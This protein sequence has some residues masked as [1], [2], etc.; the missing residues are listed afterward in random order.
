VTLILYGHLPELMFAL[1]D[2]RLTNPNTGAPVSSAATK[3]TL[4][5]GMWLHYTGL[6]EIDG[7]PTDL[8]LANTLY[9]QHHLPTAFFHLRDKLTETFRRMPWSARIKRHA[10]IGVGWV[11]FDQ[12]HTH[13]DPVVITVSNFLSPSGTWLAEAANEFTL[14]ATNL[15]EQLLPDTNPRFVYLQ[16]AGQGMPEA[17]RRQLYAQ[18][19]RI[20]DRGVISPHG[21]RL[22][23]EEMR[24]RSSSTGPVGGGQLVTVAPHPDL[25]EQDWLVLTPG[26]AMITCPRTTREYFDTAFSAVS[27]CLSYILIPE[28]LTAPEWPPAVNMVGM[29]PYV[30][31][32]T[33]SDFVF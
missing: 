28:D 29:D 5:P 26:P 31:S 14:Q 24:R 1:S 7:V 25:I 12:A 19:V 27:H 16:A 4:Y 9:G 8:W 22:L 13:Y 10:F 17:R 21:V 3:V 18:L 6:S 2:R 20:L 33:W 23:A 11:P 30:A 15:R 32:W